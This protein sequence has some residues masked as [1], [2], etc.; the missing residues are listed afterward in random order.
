MRVTSA[1]CA[2]RRRVIERR[3]KDSAFKLSQQ[4]D[5][6]GGSL[7]LEAQAR[8]GA[9]PTTAGRVSTTR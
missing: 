1:L 2:T 9:A 7:N 5:E 6:A 8:A 3:W 4:P